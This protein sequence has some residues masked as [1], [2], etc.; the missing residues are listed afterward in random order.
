MEIKVIHK[1]RSE[2]SYF[3]RQCDKSEIG[4]S[5]SLSKAKY[6]T[7]KTGHAVDVYYESWRLVADKKNLIKKIKS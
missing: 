5:N 7:L 3:C 2:E 1:G 6:H 4:K